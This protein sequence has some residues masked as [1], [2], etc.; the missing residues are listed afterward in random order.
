VIERVILSGKKGWK[1]QRKRQIANIWGRRNSHN[2]TG[3][4]RGGNV[5][6]QKKLSRREW[7]EGQKAA[8]FL[9]EK[10]RHLSGTEGEEVVWEGMT[11]F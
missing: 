4:V 8:Y 10:E 9:I 5:F 6:S 11:S 2:V 1:G 3:K 7:K